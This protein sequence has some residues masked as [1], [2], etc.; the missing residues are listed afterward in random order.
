MVTLFFVIVEKCDDGE[1]QEKIFITDRR[2]K[3]KEKV[4]ETVK[5]A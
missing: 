1:K 2:K 5:S 4:K 3:E